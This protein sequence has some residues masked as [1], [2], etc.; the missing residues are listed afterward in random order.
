MRK[1]KRIPGA[2]S[3]K[4][5]KTKRDDE[6]F[7]R[8]GLVCAAILSG[9]TEQVYAAQPGTQLLGFDLA[10]LQARGI[11]P[12]VARYFRSAARFTEGV[13]VVGLTVNGDRIGL[14][15]VRFNHE[16]ELCFTRGLLDRAG[17]QVPSRVLN[18]DAAVD[19]ACHDFL[20]EYP[21]TVATLRPGSEEVFLVVP[22]QALRELQRGSGHYVRGGTAGM[23]NYDLQGSNSHSREDTNRYFSA[24]TE[25]GFNFGDW[26]ARSRQLYISTDGRSTTEHLFAYAQRDWGPLASTLQLGQ[27]SGT[28]PVFGGV[29]LLGAQLFPDGVASGSSG[30]GVVVEGIALSQSRVEVRQSGALIYTTVVPEGPFSLN[31]LP[32]LNGTSDLQV[33]VIETRGGQRSFVVPAASFRATVPVKTGYTAGLGKVRDVDRSGAKEPLLGMASGTWALGKNSTL[34]SGVQGTDSYNSVGLALDSSFGERFSLG[35]RNNLARDRK[36]KLQGMRNSVSLGGM[37]PGNVQVSLSATTQTPGYREVLDT[38]RTVAGENDVARFKNQYTAGVSWAAAQVGAF[39]AGYSRATHFNSRSTQ[40]VYGSWNKDFSYANVGVT[41]DSQVGSSGK[42]RGDNDG[43]GVRLQVTVPLGRE[44]SLSS[45]ARH[46]GRRSSMGTTYTERVDET[47]NYE[48]RGER[49]LRGDREQAVGGWVNTLSRYAQ[50]GAGVDRDA[51]STR[52]SGQLQGAVVAHDRGVTFT[53]YRVEDTFGVASAGDIAG[54]RISTPQGPVWTDRW[55]MAVLPGLPAYQVS[56]LEIEG[57]S[58]PRQVDIKN[59]TKVLEAGRGSFSKVDFEVVKVRRVLL[60]AT[61]TAGEP[62][63][64]GASVLGAGNAFLTNV[65]AGGMIFLSNIDSAQTLTVSSP[66]G[67]SCTLQLDLAEQ[68]Y[69]ERPYETASATCR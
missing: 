8:N 27:I 29:Q 46:Q 67:A 54:A 37:L 31:N 17:L 34:S 23:L 50:V 65:V 59:G 21:N 55:G 43:V 56:Q 42:T 62:L 20:S 1:V 66:S 61:D 35:L 49:D 26:I 36:K 60:R 13:R 14:A 63:A 15:D 32:L 33:S 9:M 6:R 28:S 47:L 18:K 41:V 5:S 4:R 3:K 25:V 64:Q 57:K 69:D 48:L 39:S 7:R 22:T 51:S 38:V 11:D 19:Q 12:G 2:V 52:Y 40:N 68:S 30:G 10:T 44:R 58:L 16:G 24:S 45:F 53:P